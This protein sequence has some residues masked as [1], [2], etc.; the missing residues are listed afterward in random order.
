MIL[1]KKLLEIDKNKKKRLTKNFTTTT[2]LIKRN[3]RAY[4][5]NEVKNLAQEN[6]FMLKRLLEKTS[7]INNFK[8]MKD[9]EKNQEYKN[10][11][12][13]Y[14]SINF[15]SN[16]NN[17]PIIQSFYFNDDKNKKSF[18]SIYKTKSFQYNKRKTY[19]NN[20]KLDSQFYKSAKRSIYSKF[21][22]TSVNKTEVETGSGGDS[23]RC[24]KNGD[25]CSA[26]VSLTETKTIIK[27]GFSSKN[28]DENEKNA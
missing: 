24:S 8:L 4:F 28:G 21:N 1:F 2:N 9:Y 20:H 6:L 17:K 25:E 15:F 14:P 10:N 13:F 7:S 23:H 16:N 27:G 19:F 11:I 3:K 12:C 22:K 5:Q 26:N 18:P